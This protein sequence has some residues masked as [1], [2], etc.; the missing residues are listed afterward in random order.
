V[1]LGVIGLGNIGGAVA[2]NLVADGH[3]VTVHDADAARAR[4]LVG[5]TAV[6][7]P[8]A[9]GGAAE[10]TLLCLPT[11]EVVEEVA[12]RWASAAAAGS[13]LVDLSTNDPARVRA[14]G[15]RLAGSGHDLVEAPLT[16]GGPGAAERRLVFMVG[17][18]EGPVARALPVLRP[19]GRA[20]FHLGPLGSGNT[21]K[22]VNSLV[23]FSATWSSLEG[24]S[25][26]VKA[27]I[28]LPEAVEVIRTAGAGNFWID[29]MAES[30]DVRD[31]PTQFALG[32][33]A[34]DAAL[35]VATGEDLAVPTPFG[36]ALAEVLAGA[37]DHGLGGRD[38]SALVEVA[39]AAAGVE[40]RWGRDD[41]KRAMP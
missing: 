19:L 2:A 35:V 8:A 3:T 20:T 31:R 24:L 25:L 10:V 17:G 30:V 14:L 37:V 39:E 40:L 5:A 32:L 36:A 27:G 7:D 18:D 41:G 9:V 15:G 21:M 26:A 23:A 16:G 13:I 6:D 33:A 22:L 38:W 4:A 12:G 34:K 11:P 29:R 28:G 1:D